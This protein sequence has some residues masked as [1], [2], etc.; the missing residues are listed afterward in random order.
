MRLRALIGI[1]L[2]LALVAGGVGWWIYADRNLVALAKNVY[3]EA[4]A[5]GEPER[6]ARMVA[7]V[8]RERSRHNRRHWGGG[9]LH[10]VVYKRAAR[11]GGIVVCQ[12]SWTCMRAA[13]REPGI[14]GLWQQALSIARD[15]LA[16]RFMP[17]S[18]LK[19]ATHYL[20]AKDSARRN[21][22]WFKTNLVELGKADEE[23]RHVF[24]R[25]PTDAERRLLPKP[26]AVPECH[27]PKPALKKE[28]SAAR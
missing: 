7:Y 25:E 10:D 2:L 22:C 13:T 18:H 26:K 16:Q 14:A 23:S 5:A 11:K 1:A 9:D 20:N 6:S 15:E 27:T 17:P 3:W 4:L 19:G 12:F 28:P 21:V 8:T 24:Y